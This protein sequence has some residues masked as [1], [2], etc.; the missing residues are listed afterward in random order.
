[1]KNGTA[2]AVL[3]GL[4][5]KMMVHGGLL[6]L[7]VEHSPRVKHNLHIY[8]AKRVSFIEYISIDRIELGGGGEG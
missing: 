4:H 6:K 2:I 7:K 5:K 3:G 1:M 8:Y